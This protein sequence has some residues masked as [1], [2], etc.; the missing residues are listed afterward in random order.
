M[1]RTYTGTNPHDHH[2][3]ISVVADARG[4]DAGPWT[5]VDITPTSETIIYKPPPATLRK[6]SKGDDVKKLQAALRVTVDGDFGPMTEAALK[7]F[8][9]ANH[10]VADGICGPMTWGAL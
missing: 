9:T 2:C 3:H 4:D 7:Q 8:Q 10:L 1:W 5:L 6:G